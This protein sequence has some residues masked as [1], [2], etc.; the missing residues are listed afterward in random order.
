VIADLGADVCGVLPFSRKFAA[1]PPERFVQETLVRLLGIR[2]FVTG[3][4]Y[5]FGARGRGDVRLL[6]EL[7][8]KYNFKV[9]VVPPRFMQ[10]SI[11]SSTRIRGLVL[12]GKVEDAA[13]LLGRSFTLEGRVVRGEGVGRTLAAPTA[14]LKPHK[15]LAVPGGGVYAVRVQLG[16]KNYKAVCN[17]GTRPTFT[18]KKDRTIE[19]HLLSFMGSLYGR[20]LIVQFIRRLRSEKKFASRQELQRQIQRDITEAYRVLGK[21]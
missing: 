12:R 15:D 2:E 11:I 7:G 4:D 10:G 21:R 20:D 8:R 14:N 19:I 1:T 17:I 6:K 18:R 16:G 5:R 3:E 13:K 9:H